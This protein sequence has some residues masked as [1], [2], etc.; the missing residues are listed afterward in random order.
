MDVLE[1]L[2]NEPYFLTPARLRVDPGFGGLRGE[3][4]FEK[5]VAG[6]KV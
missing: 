1:P 3:A 5:L 2:M 4:R 6:G